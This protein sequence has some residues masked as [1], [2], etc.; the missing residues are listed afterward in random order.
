MEELDAV[1]DISFTTGEIMKCLE[2]EMFQQTVLA[3]VHSDALRRFSIG[4]TA[5]KAP[6]VTIKIDFNL[7]RL[8]FFYLFA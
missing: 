1:K 5:S 2:G 8:E 3:A 4:A 7:K 6:T